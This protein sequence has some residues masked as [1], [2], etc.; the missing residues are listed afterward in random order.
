LQR[1]K[2]KIVAETDSE[3]EMGSYN[4]S[5]DDEEGEEVSFLAPSPTDFMR[6]ASK[7]SIN[8]RYTANTLTHATPTESEN[9][10]TD[11]S[12]ASFHT[13]DESASD[14][15]FISRSTHNKSHTIK[16]Q[17]NN[18]VKP[19]QEAMDDASSASEDFFITVNKGK[20]VP[21]ITQGNGIISAPTIVPKSS[22]A[23]IATPPGKSSSRNSRRRRERI[24]E[25]T[26]V[27]DK[28]ARGK[29]IV[30]I[31]NG[32]DTEDDLAEDIENFE[33]E[34]DELPEF[35]DVYDS[36]GETPRA[37][38][39]PRAIVAQPDPNALGI[40]KPS[41]SSNSSIS[42]NPR[43]SRP[44][45][46][47]PMGPSS[48]SLLDAHKNLS[49]SPS[50]DNVSLLQGL[51]KSPSV[52]NPGSAVKGPSVK[53]QLSDSPGPSKSDLLDEGNSTLFSFLFLLTLIT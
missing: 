11:A 5:K 21:N 15:F 27:E 50:A 7:E 25:R 41:N 37:I 6:I 36:S 18:V 26:G 43:A 53:F 51:P 30:K 20:K 4:D 12:I 24:R 23:I 13:D 2:G 3:V 38:R 47:L 39:T 44:T 29:K 28:N 17:N 52:R 14:D 22:S 1:G 48:I 33:E 9:D 8:S 32:T 42:T 35:S 16:S 46:V 10:I 34:L 19:K 49:P 45:R 40:L 31:K